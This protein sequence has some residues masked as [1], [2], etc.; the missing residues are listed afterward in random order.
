MRTTGEVVEAGRGV[1]GGSGYPEYEIR[2]ADTVTT[3]WTRDHSEEETS[4]AFEVIWW[5]TSDPDAPIGERAI[6][7]IFESA[8]QRETFLVE[9]VRPQVP[10]SAAEQTF[11]RLHPLA[12]IVSEILIG[13]TFVSVY[14]QL[15][16]Q[17]TGTTPMPPHRGPMNLEVPP[18]LLGVHSKL[19]Y[20]EAGYADGLV[21]LIGQAVTETDDYLDLG[22]YIGFENGT[23]LSTPLK[24]AGGC[25]VAT[26]NTATG[27][28]VWTPT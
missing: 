15:D 7:K 23:A 18:H 26:F 6:T 11:E 24:D 4:R 8:E 28:Y 19:A 5:P 2:V 22:I 21:A 17:P 14:V 9:K 12:E 27:L 20:G 3:V 10:L 1:L 25:E 16:F 13:V